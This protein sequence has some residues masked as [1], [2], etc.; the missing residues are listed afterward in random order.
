[1]KAIFD[2]HGMTGDDVGGFLSDLV[3]KRRDIELLYLKSEEP[4]NFQV[5]RMT[6]SDGKPYSH[7]Y[8]PSFGAG[9]ARW[10]QLGGKTPADCI[11]QLFKD[12]Q[13]LIKKW[14]DKK[15]GEPN[16]RDMDLGVRVNIV[17]RAKSEAGQS[18]YDERDEM[19]NHIFD[20]TLNQR[21]DDLEEVFDGRL[22]VRLYS[23][24]NDGMAGVNCSFNISESGP[25]PFHGFTIYSGADVLSDT[26]MEKYSDAFGN[27]WNAFLRILRRY[28]VQEDICNV[29]SKNSADLGD[30]NQRK[31]IFYHEHLHK[32]GLEDMKGVRQLSNK[33]FQD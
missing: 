5:C 20:A 33:V 4:T 15:V 1:M 23:A 10:H 11:N 14:I 22:V 26:L 9:L 7:K 30:F 28:G 18:R 6:R 16:L 3:R 32:S 19:S 27:K 13:A 24:I 29:G 21:G 25:S 2:K 8:D 31:F 17:S 12:A